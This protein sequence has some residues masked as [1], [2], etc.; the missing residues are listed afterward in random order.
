MR[1]FWNISNICCIS[2]PGFSPTFPPLDF[3]LRIIMHTKTAFKL[4][5]IWNLPAVK[6]ENKKKSELTFCCLKL[7]CQLF[8]DITLKCVSI[9]SYLLKLLPSYVL[10]FYKHQRRRDRNS[11][12]HFLFCE[13]RNITAQKHED[14][15]NKV[16]CVGRC[17]E[18]VSILIPS[19]WLVVTE[20]HH[21]LQMKRVQAQLFI[22]RRISAFLYIQ[23]VGLLENSSAHVLLIYL[24]KHPCFTSK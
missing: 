16:K 23:F 15:L 1:L 24:P 14:K 19:N 21:R 11:L 12:K 5:W 17:F 4:W 9:R 3:S 22:Q 10:K 7:F 6:M 2:F 20:R 18:H 13:K 8:T